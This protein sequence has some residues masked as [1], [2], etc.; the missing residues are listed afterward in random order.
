MPSGLRV[1]RDLAKPV[2]IRWEKLRI[3]YNIVLLGIVLALILQNS[4]PSRM[5]L[6]H[7]LHYLIGA[8]LAN[9]CFFAAPAIETY[10]A[11]LG[12]RSL[13]LTVF[14]FVGGLLISAP[15]VMMYVFAIP[16]GISIW[17]Y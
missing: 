4:A 11:W 13:W 8:V 10:A 16:F 5:S 9:I 3:P 14:L 1:V 6:W 15:L 12:W 17:P 7:I 2:F